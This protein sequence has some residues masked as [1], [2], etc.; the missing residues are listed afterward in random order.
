MESRSPQ[1]KRPTSSSSPLS[2]WAPQDNTR[3]GLGRN[4]HSFFGQGAFLHKKIEFSVHSELA[5]HSSDDQSSDRASTRST[6][7]EESRGRSIRDTIGNRHSNEQSS[8]HSS[9]WRSSDDLATSFDPQPFGTTVSIEATQ[10][11]KANE[12][13]L[14][15]MQGLEQAASMK[16]WAG[17][18]KPA[19]AWGKLI[20]VSWVILT[21]TNFDRIDNC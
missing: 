18:G 1:N 8:I 12:P 15:K 5:A 3:Q 19:E 7:R 17:E 20:K 16:R 14:H 11:V 10:P 9:A 6:I 21:S 2:P 13:K 4:E